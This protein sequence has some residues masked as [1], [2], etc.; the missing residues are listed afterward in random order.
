[1]CTKEGRLRVERDTAT[2]WKSGLVDS[3]DTPALVY[4]EQKL[5][6]L[7]DHGLA[8]RETAG[9]KLLYAVKASALSDVLLYLSPKVD[10]FAVSSLF[11]ARLLRS[12]SPGSA[13]HLTTP[14]LRPDEILELGELCEFVALNSVGQLER[15]GASLAQRTSL[16]IRLNTRVSSVT[17]RRYDPCSPKSKL[18]IPIEEATAVFTSFPAEIDGIHIHTNADSS[19][20]GELLANVEVLVSSLPE[21]LELSW[22]NLG[23]GYLFENSP[24]VGPLIEAVNLVQERFGAEVYLEPGAGL[25]RSGGYLVSS[26]LDVFDV[27]GSRIAVLDTTVN[28]MPE[29][30]EFNYS[31]DVL[32]QEENGLFEYILAGS[33]CLAGD[34]FG[35]YR[36]PE[37][38]RVGAKVVFEDAGAYTLTKAHRFNGVNLPEV[39]I[40]GADGEY[41]VL[42]VFD[43]TDFAAHWMTNG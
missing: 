4:D 24:D 16:G 27:D 14:G 38:L 34:V 21:G 22:V 5:M 20:F 40:L 28:H 15:F 25:V 6:D 23:G 17:D 41:R 12:L 33:T 26:V 36:F 29:V 18:G 1:M 32:G 8:C 7:L 39:G 10:G 42:K 43:F 13:L 2:R 11:E 37:R 19:D 35:T 9:F 30:L 31:P 3:I